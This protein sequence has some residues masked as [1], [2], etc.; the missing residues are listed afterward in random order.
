[1]IGGNTRV[2][3]DAPPYFLYSGFDIEP[4]GLNAVGLKRAGFS[5][6]EIGNLK[7][8]YQLLFREGLT[9]ERALDRIEAEIDSEHARHLVNF[10]RA[11]RRGVCR[12][13]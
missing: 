10:V 7:R 12:P 8:A 6:A 1:M 4:C 9:L 11:S 5:L 13:S 2:N 3:L